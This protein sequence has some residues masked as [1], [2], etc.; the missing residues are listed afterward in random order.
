MTDEMMDAN[1]CQKKTYQSPQIKSFI[2]EMEQDIATGSASVGSK[3]PKD[4]FI[5][6]WEIANDRETT[7]DWGK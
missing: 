7:I 3:S 2:V 4:D 5:Q 1:E 6:E